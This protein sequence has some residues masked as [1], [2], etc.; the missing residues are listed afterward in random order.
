MVLV[1]GQWREVEERAEEFG[2]DEGHA[3]VSV[4]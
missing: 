4:E 1:P 3:I 2:L